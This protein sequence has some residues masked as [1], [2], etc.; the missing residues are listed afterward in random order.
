MG[1]KDTEEESEGSSTGA[2]V[3]DASGSGD[4]KPDAGKDDTSGDEKEEGE[5]IR[6]RQEEI[7]EKRYKSQ[8]LFSPNAGCI[9]KNPGN[10]SA[11]ALRGD[12]PIEQILEEILAAGLA[13]AAPSS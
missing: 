4:E 9:F 8:P 10:D 12:L 3:E 13:H 6:K 1:E 11:A 7:L 5:K 2:N